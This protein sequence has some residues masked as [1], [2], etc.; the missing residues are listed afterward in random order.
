M[1][2]PVAETHM[3]EDVAYVMIGAIRFEVFGVEILAS[4][5]PD[6]I[7]S[8]EAADRPQGRQDVI[9]LR[10][11]LRRRDPGNW[12]GIDAMIEDGRDDDG[13]LYRPAKVVLHC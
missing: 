7:R 10:E 2:L 9:V 12:G 8:K 1:L 11:I 13:S 3:L 6:I 5:L 4:D